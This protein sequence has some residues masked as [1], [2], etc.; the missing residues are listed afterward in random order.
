MTLLLFLKAHVSGYTKRDGTV[1]QPHE[2]S[3]V[4]ANDWKPG[5]A[6]ERIVARLRDRGFEADVQ[7][8]STVAGRS[9]YVR[10]SDPPS[11]WHVPISVRVSDHSVGSTR[12]RDHVHVTGPDAEH[13]PL[14]IAMDMRAKE[15]ERQAAKDASDA[16]E[17]VTEKLRADRRREDESGRQRA[18]NLD[19]RVALAYPG[20]W[21]KWTGKNGPAASKARRLLRRRYESEYP[22]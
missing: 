1:V 2:D 11:G 5:A 22:T 17:A 3:R 15:H 19:E 8:W 9:S 7:H 16:A 20:E 13:V 4:A 21:R 18:A 14:Q 10:M 6:A 12:Y